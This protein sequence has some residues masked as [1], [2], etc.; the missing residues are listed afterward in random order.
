MITNFMRLRPPPRPLGSAPFIPMEIRLAAI[1]Q[2]LP[3]GKAH[4]IPVEI[5][6]EIFLHVGVETRPWDRQNLMLVCRRWHAVMLSTPGITSRLRIRRSTRKEVVQAFIQR[7]KSRFS[8][9]VDVNDERDGKDFNA[10]EFHASFMAVV[11]VAS[12]WRSLELDSFPPPGEYKGASIVVQPLESLWTFK[13]SQSSDIG[14]FFEPLM[15]AVATTAAPHLT[16]MHLSNLNAVLY[17][18]QPAYLHVFCNLTTLKILLS[19]RMASP[20]NI[21]PYLQRVEIFFATHLHLPIYSDDAPLPLI[22]TLHHLHLKCVSVQWMAGRVFPVLEHCRITFPLHIDTICLRS[23]VMPACA[24]L[25]YISNDLNSLRFFHDLPLDSLYVRSGQWNV[26]RGNAQLVAMCPIVVA[27]AQSLTTLDVDVKCSEQL[28]LLLL[29]LVPALDVLRLRLASP[30]ALSDA[31][32]QAFVA[33]Q[34][35]A[36]STHEMAPLP[37]LLLGQ[38]LRTLNVEYQR[39]L[40]GP[41]RKT[42]IAVFGDIVSSRWQEEEFGRHLTFSGSGRTTWVVGKPEESFHRALRDRRL[43]VGISSARGIIPLCEVGGPSMEVPFK[44]AE[45]LAAGHELSFSHLLTLHHLVELRFRDGRGVLPD[46]LPP[47][48]RLFHTLGVLEA[49]NIHPSFLAGQTF[50]KLQGCRISLRGEGPK[51]SQGQVTQMPICTRVDVKDIALLATFELPQ[52]CELGTSFVHPEF[53]LIWETHIA[54]NANLSGLELLHLYG[55]N[56]RA[57]LVQA[58]GFLPALKTLIITNGSYP[59]ADFFGIFLP[60]DSDGT[61]ASRQSCDEAQKSTILC[62]MLR[63]LLIEE[64]DLTDQIELISVLEKVVTLRG[65]AGYPLKTFTFSDFRCH[66]RFELIGS[67]GGFVLEQGVLGEDDEPFRL[68][69]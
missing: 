55:W 68:D 8:V 27:S 44:E 13:M 23:V 39:W 67:N 1:H 37:R 57:D 56:Q 21:L 33:T 19:K 26:R 16:E 14:I 50:H 17:L 40:R 31:F 63:E 59:D 4:L 9:I 46:A 52:I 29:G 24:S 22:Q 35:S 47:N 30:H 3:P 43:I 58:L 25:T 45:Y 34:S 41:E 69:I 49:E 2:L 38:K 65:V 64:C 28:L 6:C 10:D 60:M 54:V 11:Q 18:V 12:R 61:S 5:L 48:F 62:P 36:D 32:F 51:L 15:T 7:R 66:K 42:L 53:N 20:A